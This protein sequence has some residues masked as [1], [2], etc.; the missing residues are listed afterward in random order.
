MQ[1]HNE[2]WLLA[3]NVWKERNEALHREKNYTIAHQSAIDLRIR[4]LYGNKGLICA[5]DSHLI[6]ID[7]EQLI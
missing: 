1:V 4:E 2:I 3:M 5:K 7:L 6:Y